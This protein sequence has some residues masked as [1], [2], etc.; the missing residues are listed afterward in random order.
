MKTEFEMYNY[1]KDNNYYFGRPKKFD[2]VKVHLEEIESILNQ[3]EDVNVICGTYIEGMSIGVHIVAITNYRIIYS[4]NDIFGNTINSIN[5][6]KFT[7]MTKVNAK[8]VSNIYI[9]CIG[10]QIHFYMNLEKADEL[11]YKM[12]NVIYDILNLSKQKNSISPADEI[13]KY[14]EL[15]DYGA[16]T[17]DEFDKKKKEL[18][19]L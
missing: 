4:C 11:F 16:I 13:K 17:Q 19:N 7:D 6:E 15:L 10:E 12:Q 5:L 9:D 18:L 1:I 14:K 3:N 8:M 2:D